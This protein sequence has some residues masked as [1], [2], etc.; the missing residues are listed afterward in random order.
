MQYDPKLKIAM[1]EIR[2]ILDKYDAGGVVMIHRPGFIEFVN[3]MNPSYS[4]AYF[5]HTPLGF[6][7]RFK[8]KAADYEN[9]KDGRNEAVRATYNMFS[10]MVDV[11][12]RQ[13]M[14]WEQSLKVLEQG[15]GYSSA[16]NTPSQITGH[17][18]Q[19]N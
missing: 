5:E 2:A 14:M 13:W 1:Q 15:T 18:E 12:G 6:A 11:M 7:V 9:G 8:A 16:D 17:D 4:C 10:S 3:K 19:N